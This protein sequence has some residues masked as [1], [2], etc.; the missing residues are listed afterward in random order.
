MKNICGDEAKEFKCPSADA[1]YKVSDLRKG[2]KIYLIVNN[3][4]P[5]TEFYQACGIL[6]DRILDSSRPI[7]SC[8]FL[9]LKGSLGAFVYSDID[10][11]RISSDHCKNKLPDSVTER[12]QYEHYECDGVCD[13]VDCKDESTCNGYTYGF[14]C[15]NGDYVPSSAIKCSKRI[16]KKW[17]ASNQT[18]G[19]RNAAQKLQNEGCAIASTTPRC[20]S[21]LT[22]DVDVII[23]RK[24]FSVPLFNFS[25]CG[26]LLG[27]Y[28]DK[29]VLTWNP[30]FRPHFLCQNRLDQTN[31]SDPS[32]VGLFCKIG[33]IM[34]S[35]SRLVICNKHLNPVSV[36]CDD[37]ID[38]QCLQLSDS[39]Y[40]HK[41]QLCNG[42]NDCEYNTDES[43]HMC[44]AMTRTGC[45]RRLGK[46]QVKMFPL[47]WIR[48]GVWDCENKI[49]ESKE[50][51]TCGYGKTFRYQTLVTG[52]PCSEVYLCESGYVDLSELCDRKESCGN[53]KRVCSISRRLHSTFSYPVISRGTNLLFHCLYGLEDLQIKM[54]SVC[55]YTQFLFHSDDVFGRNSY[56]HLYIP[57]LT[58][59]DC[60]FVYGSIYVFLGCPERCETS[61]CPLKKSLMHNSCSGQF[62][63]RVFTM[64]NDAYLTFLIKMTNPGGNT[65]YHSDVF[66]CTNGFCVGY[67]KLC[68]LVDDCGDDSD[69]QNCTNRFQCEESNEALPLN[70]FCDGIIDCLDLTDECNGR[71]TRR[72]VDQYGLSVFGWAIG[73]FATI[74]NAITI[75]HK[76][77]MLKESK[78]RGSF[79]NSAILILLCH[80]DLL[81]GLYILIVLSFDLHYGSLLCPM[82]LEW[83]TSTTCAALGILSFEGSFISVLAMAW[84]SLFRCTGIIRGRIRSEDNVH[85][86]DAVIFT[87]VVFALITISLFI[88]LLPLSKPVE[89]FFV[90]GLYYGPNNPL[91]I[92]APDRNKHKDIL[93]GYYGR[94]KATSLDWKLIRNLVSGMFSNDH[95]GIFYKKL[96]FYGNDPVCSFKFFVTLDDP[97]HLFVWTIL[98]LCLVVF[99]VMSASY[100]LVWWVALRRSAPLLKEMPNKQIQR[101]NRKLQRKV[102]AIISTNLVCWV[103]FILV[104]VLH[105]AE[106]LDATPWYSFFSLIVIPS[107]SVINPIILNDFIATIFHNAISK[108]RA[109]FGKNYQDNSLATADNTDMAETQGL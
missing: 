65:Q 50:W 61:S 54:N 84:L 74:F 94:I 66:L 69:E 33:G 71:C 77:I 104:C 26:P 76:I 14:H 68:N 103:P 13:E 27:Y 7:L 9:C 35:V 87:V 29:D 67:D 30:K 22:I 31:C 45:R 88:A 72:I 86:R 78:T 12:E 28:N 70:H 81:T 21:S 57:N 23:Y 11:N 1:H 42:E 92:G 6:P 105:A 38:A 25:R 96:Q 8:G 64:A 97:Q 95:S 39:C 56:P 24:N 51:K 5:G 102:A 19:C 80:G 52:N 53:E 91:F 85:R 62:P 10:L 41:H 37:G 15:D 63:G 89:D 2:S 36:L 99:V 32:R 109:I 98:A 4:C 101:R 108:L 44:S 93:E 60:Q 73:I 48:D 46:N 55:E 59:L 47:V 18:S 40:I 17:F 16:S 49:D 3:T 34:S 90:N 83:L 82:Q 107:N 58:K 43:H 100:I 106:V 20:K 75:P 79:Q